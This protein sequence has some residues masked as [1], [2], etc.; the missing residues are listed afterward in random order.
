MAQAVWSLKRGRAGGLSGMRA[1]D[2]K[3]WLGE[4]SREMD[5][6]TYRWQ[7]L[8]RLIQTTFKDGAVPEEVAWAMMVFLPKGRGGGIGG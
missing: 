2:L 5:P 8:V 1:E 6:V 7:L 4:A 3:V